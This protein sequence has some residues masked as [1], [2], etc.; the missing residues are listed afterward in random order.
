MAEVAACAVADGATIE[1]RLDAI[2]ATYGNLV[3][4]EKSLR[5]TPEVAVSRVAVLTKNPPAEIAGRAVTGVEEYPDA[6]LLRLWCGDVR[7]Q[8]RPSGTEPKVK[9]YGEAEDL[10]PMP[11]LDALAALLL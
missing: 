6:G 10:N 8:V 11:Y 9:L 1:D 2:R 4:A 7:L 3:T 5:M